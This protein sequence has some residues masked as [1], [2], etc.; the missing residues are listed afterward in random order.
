MSCFILRSMRGGSWVLDKLKCAVIFIG[1]LRILIWQYL[2][3]RTEK[4]YFYWLNGSG[5][6][7]GKNTI[8]YHWPTWF[9]LYFWKWHLA[10]MFWNSTPFDQNYAFLGEFFFPLKRE[11]E[12][13]GTLDTENVLICH[14][15]VKNSV[16]GCK[17]NSWHQPHLL[18]AQITWGRRRLSFNQVY[19]LLIFE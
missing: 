3:K 12:N 11:K 5:K 10:I 15:V 19:N 2:V 4:N 1:N 16:W 7:E 9:P 18:R 13:N 6:Y 8:N 14:S 17:Y